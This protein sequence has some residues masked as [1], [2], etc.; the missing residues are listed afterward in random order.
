MY[1]NENKTWK[2]RNTQKFQFEVIGGIAGTD[3]VGRGGCVPGGGAPGIP[4]GLG[5]TGILGGTIPGLGGGGKPIG[6]GITI[7]NDK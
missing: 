3:P 5:G 1:F 7:P 6:G 4:G 2:E